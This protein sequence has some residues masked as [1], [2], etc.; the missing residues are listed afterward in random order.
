MVYFEYIKNTFKSRLWYRLNWAMRVLGIILS[1]WIQI[2][3]WNALIT[4][5]ENVVTMEYM[6][7]YIL[8][9]AMIQ[10][11]VQGDTIGIV[12][13]KIHS[14]QI[15]MDMIK[16]IRFRTYMFCE[17][18]GNSLF[19][20]FFQ[21]FPVI[22]VA[23]VIFKCYWIWSSVDLLFVFSVILGMYLYFS[24]AYCFALT[25][26]WW[27]QT[28]IL[29]RFLNDFISLF[30]GKM[31][32]VWM[33]PAVILTA[34]RFLP[35]QY[36]YYTPIAILLNDPTLQ[37][38]VYWIGIQLIWCIVFTVLGN[39]IERRGMHKLQVQGG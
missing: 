10:S 16:P 38:K 24:I 1:V 11:L 2:C 33:F 12:N 15:A 22:V 5:H 8:F 35:F 31:I 29:G 36:I 26:F 17:H 14:G 34:N 23:T 25:S 7:G 19:S 13:Q 32:P 20:F 9:S 28:W 21:Y 4:N 30:S 39:V 6:I 3:L 18:V 27:T 37:E